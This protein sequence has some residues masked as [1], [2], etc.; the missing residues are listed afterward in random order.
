MSQKKSVKKDWS[1]DIY[2]LKAA[3]VIISSIFGLLILAQ[4]IGTLLGSQKDNLSN[5]FEI[6]FVAIVWLV[7]VAWPFLGVFIAL[8]FV[9]YFIR[10][11]VLKALEDF[12]NRKKL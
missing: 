1:H 2:A 7:S 11:T 8:W 5:I 12:E 3:A 6:I 10:Y 9:H 4:F